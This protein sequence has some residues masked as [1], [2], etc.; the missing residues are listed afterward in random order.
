MAKK[1][2]SVKVNLT[3]LS[4]A[5]PLFFNAVRSLGLE[6]SEFNHTTLLSPSLN[7]VHTLMFVFEKL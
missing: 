2:T 7:Q 5:K 4:G 6:W 3:I 1:E